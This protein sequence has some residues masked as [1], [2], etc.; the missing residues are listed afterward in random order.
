MRYEKTIMKTIGRVAFFIF[1]LLPAAAAAQAR[2]HIVFDV[3]TGTVLDAEK[4]YQRWYPASLTKLM[5]VYIAFKAVRDGEKTLTSP[6]IITRKALAQPP[7]KM[8]FPV[9]S[10]LTLDNAIKI[11]IVKSAN[12]VAVAVAQSIGGSEA[13]FVDRMNGEAMLLGMTGTHFA[14]PNG[15][16]SPD[17]YSNAHDLALL[18]RA[19]R[20]NFP[21]FAG[22]FGLEAIR[23]GKRRMRTYNTMIGRFDGA[24]GMKTGFVCE[25]GFNLIATATRGSLT[26]GA[27]VLGASSPV[28]RAERAADLL[29]AGFQTEFAGKPSLWNLMAEG[30]RPVAVDLRPEICGRQARAQNKTERDQD[31]K[32]IFH[33]PNLH[34]MDHEPEAVLITLG[35]ADGIDGNFVQYADVPKPTP[36]PDYKRSADISGSVDDDAHGAMTSG[37]DITADN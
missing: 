8:G 31:G 30:G 22:Y 2:P 25:S 1:M 20:N 33:T 4:P 19:L 12:D 3:A 27:V 24:D 34:N 11:L 15:L 36:R 5:T 32:I 16:F 37:G 26:L 29:T 13:A 10:V 35:G 17:N 6:V 9:G 7:S 14:S 23:F 18:T 28:D 21:Q